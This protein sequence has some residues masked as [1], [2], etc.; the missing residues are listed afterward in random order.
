[1]DTVLTN[2]EII[3]R[4]AVSM[5]I[6][7]LVGINREKYSS[8]GVRTHMILSVG[9]CVITL[10]QVNMTAEILNFYKDHPEL[11]GAIRSD[12]FR[13]TAQIVS[14]IGFLG[15]GLILV[16]NMRTVNGMT[17]A[18]S[19]W[20]VAGISIAIGYGEYL[21]SLL[22]ATFM[23][24][25]LK[26]FNHKKI[27]YGFKNFKVHFKDCQIDRDELNEFLKGYNG[28][29]SNYTLA[30]VDYKDHTQYRYL[31]EIEHW[32]SWNKIEFLDD[33]REKYDDIVYIE[34]K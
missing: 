2:W 30:V 33:F 17:S 13:L 4:L 15:S 10:L 31:F 19:L 11:M 8:A 27:K 28:E 24:L 9:V 26:K 23:F 1:M 3:F 25:A 22:G 7:F 29:I 20:T 5:F 21:I 14:G 32:G 18:V 16:R 6:G 12:T 34:I